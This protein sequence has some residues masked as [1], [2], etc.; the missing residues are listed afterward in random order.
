MSAERAVVV[1]LADINC[2]CRGGTYAI[3]ERFRQQCWQ[4]GKSWTCPYCKTGWGYSNNNENARLK[5]EL[6]AEKR[7]K[8]AAL[9]RANEESQRR[10][11]TEHRLR[12]QK[13]LATKLRHRAAAG[14]CPCCNRTFANLARHMGTKHPDYGSESGS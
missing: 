14:V 9:A 10:L 6:E 13:G 3:N 7:R 4:E 12:A 2:G 5:R 11:K 8:D 1:T